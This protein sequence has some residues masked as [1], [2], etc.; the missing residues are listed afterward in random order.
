MEKMP[1]SSYIVRFNDCDPLGHLNNARYIDYFLNARED[2]LREQYGIDLREWASR[3]I[4]FVV[5]HH[6]IRYLRPV[7]YN[8]RVD[9]QSAL[10]A[11]GESWLL[12]E[13]LMFDAARQLKAIM[14]TRFARIDPRTGKRAAHP[15]ELL[16]WAKETLVEGIEVEKGLGGRVEK[17]RVAG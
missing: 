14:W 9:I 12:V 13:M 15:E 5:S 6:D 11:W 3:G 2:H 7:T 4:V 1:V 17:L 16:E 8:E 10:I